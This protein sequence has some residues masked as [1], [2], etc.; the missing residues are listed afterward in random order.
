MP[1][2]N[3]WTMNCVI[4]GA[5]LFKQLYRGQLTKEEAIAKIRSLTSELRDT[6]VDYLLHRVQELITG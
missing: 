2:N 3:Q 4:F 6:E 1:T 5:D